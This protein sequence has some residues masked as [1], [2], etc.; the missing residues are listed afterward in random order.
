MTL[1]VPEVIDARSTEARP[2]GDA[3]GQAPAPAPPDRPRRR[4]LRPGHPAWIAV[5]GVAAVLV[6]LAMR[7]GVTNDA[8]WHWAA[9]QW[10]LTHHA[11]IRHDVFSYTVAGRPWVAEEWGFEVVLAWLVRA[12]GG[13]GFWLAA[14]GP[15]VAALLIGVARWRRQGSGMLRVAGL[16]VVAGCYLALGQSPRPQVA[17]YACFSLLLLLLTLARR[18]AAWLVAVPPLLCVWANLHGSFLAGLAV[19]VLDAALSLRPGRRGRVEVGPGLPRRAAAV[20]VGA[21]VLA[22]LVNPHGPGLL[23]YAWHV[24]SAPQLAADITEWQSP[25][26]HS[27][28]LL[29]LVLGPVVLTMAWL[30]LT[31]VV[32]DAFDLVLW[33]GLLLASLHSQRFLPYAG[34]AWCGLAARAWRGRPDHLRPTVLTWPLAAVA[35]A[36]LVVGPHVA[37]GTPVRA[38]PGAEPVAAVRW[39]EGHPGRVFSEY[40]WDDYLISQGLPV[41]VDGRTDLYFGTGVLGRYLAVA[42]VTTRPDPVLD[43]WHVSYVL[44]PTSTPLAVYLAHDPAWRVVFRSGPG[45]VFGRTRE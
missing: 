16:A 2:P 23:S 7:S 19:L 28:L 18:R 14:A 10:M 40:T 1:T 9:G 31:D 6:R 13:V 22:T 8:W 30:A 33:G 42:G 36:A 21:S 4:L 26:F 12:F 17:S 11:V 32:V 41:F 34:L 37:A 43:Q 5:A 25:N 39:L 24:S 38:G 29:V 3:P 44:W 20:T 45:V 27:L 35:V 15:T